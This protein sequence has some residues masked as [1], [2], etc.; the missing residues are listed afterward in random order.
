MQVHVNE[1]ELFKCNPSISM[2]MIYIA[3]NC[4]ICLMYSRPL[5]TWPTL[6]IRLMKVRKRSFFLFF[7]FF[8]LFL[9]WVSL[10]PQNI[11]VK[12]KQTIKTKIV[13]KEIDTCI[14]YHK[15]WQPWFEIQILGTIIFNKVCG[16]LSTFGPTLS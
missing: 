5:S 16:I 13:I 12:R 11:S 10:D 8:S 14:K 2:Q 6:A 4:N 15:S 7:F 1:Q 9:H 3:H